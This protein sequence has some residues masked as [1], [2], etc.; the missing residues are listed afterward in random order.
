MSRSHG[1]RTQVNLTLDTDLIEELYKQS[2]TVGISR[3]GRFIEP[4][5]QKEVVNRYMGLP[6]AP[7]R[8]CADRYPACHDKCERFKVFRKERHAIVKKM[9][10]AERLE[11]LIAGRES[12]R[13]RH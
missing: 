8:G 4:Y 11:K 13:P 9:Q 1:N 3:V 10:D 12:D 5:L 7:C 6:E 2:Y